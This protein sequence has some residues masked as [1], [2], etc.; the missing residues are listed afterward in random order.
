MA[1]LDPGV[2][3]AVINANFKTIAEAET[4]S[5]QD[6]KN[7][8]RIIAEKGTGN[9]LMSMDTTNVDVS[10]SQGTKTVAEA[11]LGS[12]ITSLTAALA[13]AMQQLAAAKAKV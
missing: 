12:Q 7:R 10:E 9:T 6:S 13:T 8:I 3:E 1:A 11:G 4:I 2:I 5:S